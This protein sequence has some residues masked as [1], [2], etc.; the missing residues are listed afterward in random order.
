MGPEARACFRCR[1]DRS[2]KGG[3]PCTKKADEANAPAYHSEVAYTSEVD[4]VVRL[5]IL[6]AVCVPVVDVAVAEM[7]GV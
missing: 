7:V 2:P 5:K 3:C 1:P 4:L 6:T